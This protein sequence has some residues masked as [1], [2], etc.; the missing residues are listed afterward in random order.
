MAQREGSI[1]LYLFI[2]ASVLFVVMTVMFFVDNAEKE[3]INGQL[4]TVTTQRDRHQADL[5]E[6]AD[7]I[8]RLKTLVGGPTAAGE[9][10][11]PE[12]IL[13]EMK[14]KIE[15]PMNEALAVLKEAKR[16]Y[17]HLTA[18]WSDVQGLLQKLIQARNEAFG[19]ES[20]ASDTLVKAKETSKV[21][22]DDLRKKHEEKLTELADLQAKY[23]DLDG[24]S[25]AEKADLVKQMETAADECSGNIIKL[26]RTVVFK[27][28]EIR[29]L[30]ARIDKL[31]EESRKLKGIDEI[32][33]DGTILSV[34]GSSGKAWIGLGRVDHLRSGTVF[35]VFQY[36]KGAKKQFKGK[37]EVTKVD[38]TSSEVRIVEETDSLNPIVAGDM[39][40]SPFYD[41]DAQPIFVFAGNELESKD[42][43]REM[44]VSKIKACGGQVQD[45]VE[46]STDFLV[47]IKNY[48]STTE[49]KTARELAVPVLRERDLLEFIGR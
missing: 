22:E 48:E 4:A 12:R 44:L 11:E 27:D 34:L 3:R 2:V 47:A 15:A 35:S 19:R 28:N 1:Y 23:E 42:L 40:T 16:E 14:E 21:A 31:L 5:K 13:T 45:K 39:V 49:Y 36:V 32:L 6:R 25:K 30:K 33:P 10:W 29:A 9:E 20:A 38:E 43:T 8:T 7:T 26:N 17:G 41:K 37:V 24:R 18:F 46:I